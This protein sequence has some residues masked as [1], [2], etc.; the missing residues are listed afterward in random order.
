MNSALC[1]QHC[2]SI[3]NKQ[4]SKHST[5]LTALWQYTMN[6][7]RNKHSTTLTSVWQYTMNKQHNKHS[8]TLTALWQY[9]I[10]KQHKRHSTTLTALWQYTINKQHNKHSNTLTAVWQYNIYS[11]H[12]T[13][14]LSLYLGLARTVYLH[15]IYGDFPAL[16]TVCTPYILK[17]V[18][19][20]PTPLIPHPPTH[21]HTI[22]TTYLQLDWPLENTRCPS[23][24]P[25]RY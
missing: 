3:L 10:N 16:T 13:T 4:H 9:T 15:R 22:Q 18:W 25:C 1:R 8:T 12:S 14:L 11:K 6:K 20:W 19:F 23:A 24:R 17:N 2:G 21:P 5:T 7:Q